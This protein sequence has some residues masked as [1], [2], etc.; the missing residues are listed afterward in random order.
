MLDFPFVDGNL[1]SSLRGVISRDPITYLTPYHKG[2]SS[3][4]SRRVVCFERMFLGDHALNL[5]T[6]N[7]QGLVQMNERSPL[8]SSYVDACRGGIGQ[9]LDRS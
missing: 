2:L 4:S 6:V 7:P 3:F 5:L 9:T 8:P 1:G